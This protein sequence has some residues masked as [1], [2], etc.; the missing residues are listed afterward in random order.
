[1]TTT[2]PPRLLSPVMLLPKVLSEMRAKHRSA[3]SKEVR[4]QSQRLRGDKHG[5]RH[6]P[7][8]REQ[9]WQRYNSSKALLTKT[10]CRQAQLLPGRGR[11]RS[12]R[13]VA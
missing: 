1:M 9:M 13:V 3:P 4:R 10:S 11:A 7:L 8:Q 5:D 6:G 12:Q 2:T